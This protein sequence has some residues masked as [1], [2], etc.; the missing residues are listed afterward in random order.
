MQR[1]TTE[2]EFDCI[3]FKDKVQLE[4]YEETKC[5]TASELVA[6]FRRKVETGPFAEMVACCRSRSSE[7]EASVGSSD[8]TYRVDS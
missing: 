2:K 6:Y 3:A 4:I 5:M 1:K 8:P 7:E